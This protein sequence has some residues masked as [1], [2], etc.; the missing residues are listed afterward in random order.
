[1]RDFVPNLFRTADTVVN[2]D[3]VLAIQVNLLLRGSGL[4]D[5][6]AVTNYVYNGASVTPTD[7]R[8]RRTYS[9]TIQLRNRTL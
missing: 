9:A 5:N 3:N 2:W 6:Q 4:R 1:M 8:L 7:R